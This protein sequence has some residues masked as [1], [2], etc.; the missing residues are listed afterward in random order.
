MAASQRGL[1]ATLA[2]SRAWTA[3]ARAAACGA[4]AWPDSDR[5]R[6]SRA[7][8]SNAPTSGARRTKR[9]PRLAATV[10]LDEYDQQLRDEEEGA[11]QYATEWV[12]DLTADELCEP[13][14]QSTAARAGRELR[15]E[16]GQYLARASPA[17]APHGANP[18]R[19]RA[20]FR[21]R[22]TPAGRRADGMAGTGRG[23][24]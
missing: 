2:A 18:S 16:I 1:A 19:R 7:R 15:A 6:S 21:D 10:E 9:R 20:P 11:F 24:A 5:R 17:A 13:Q 12:D 3:V 4:G 14:E 8:S 23:A 22:G